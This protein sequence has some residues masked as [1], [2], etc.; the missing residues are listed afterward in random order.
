MNHPGPNLP[1]RLMFQQEQKR[2]WLSNTLWMGRA[3][4]K[5]V[6]LT[7]RVDNIPL[8][9]RAQGCNL[10][11]LYAIGFY[12]AP[13]M[14]MRRRWCDRCPFTNITIVSGVLEESSWRRLANS[15]RQP[16]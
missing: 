4:A 6:V 3:G 15:I 9:W 8:L 12:L 5:A 7:Y 1:M 2:L 11:Q 13:K 10:V 14:V 16:G